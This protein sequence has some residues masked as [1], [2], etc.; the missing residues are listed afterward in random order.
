ML[1][2]LETVGGWVVVYKPVND[3]W[4]SPVQGE[5]Y[6]SGSVWLVV[7]LRNGAGPAAEIPETAGAGPHT[8]IRR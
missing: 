8:E 5:L 3:G 7:P 6:A 1:A 2:Y 4:I